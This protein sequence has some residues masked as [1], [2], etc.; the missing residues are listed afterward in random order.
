MKTPKLVGA[1]L[2]TAAVAGCAFMQPQPEAPLAVIPARQIETQKITLG[3][4]QSRV[5]VGAYSG[6]VIEALGSPNQVTSNADGGETWV[7]DKL[8][9]EEEYAKGKNSG[10]NVKSSRTLIVVVKFDK[11]K[12][13]KD[14]QYRQTSY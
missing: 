11:K 10:V 5:Q 8:T 3:S 7:Y 14:V 2:A 6:D 9:T 13:V 12:R 1:F 4:V